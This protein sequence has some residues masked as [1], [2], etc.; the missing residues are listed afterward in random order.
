MGSFIKAIF[1][2]KDSSAQKAQIDANAQDR[3]LFERLAGESRDAAISLTGAGRENQN[4]AFEQVLQL[5]GASIP[6]QLSV[7]QQGNIGAQRQ[8][9]QGLPN[10]QAA[11]MGNPINMAAMQPTRISY[12]T[13]FMNQSLPK[14]KTIDEALARP[15]TETEQPDL[16]NLLSGLDWGR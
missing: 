13:D 15:E 2:G 12:N 14:F 11:L 1:G 7:Q 16:S 8:L 6:Q 3:A 4:M 10:I 9:I 5:L